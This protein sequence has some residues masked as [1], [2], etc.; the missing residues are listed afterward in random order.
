[1]AH[2]RQ[3]RPDSGLGSQAKVL[4]KFSVVPFL[5]GSGWGG[6]GCASSSLSLS[7]LEMS[8]AKVYEPSIRA[9]LGTAS[10]FCEVVVL[11]ERGVH[12]NLGLVVVH[13]HHHAGPAWCVGSQVTGVPRPQE[14]AHPFRT[15]LGP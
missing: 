11:N 8:D 7:S 9:L 4:E 5:R 10:H 14:N 13:G 1:M 3:S 2:T 15:H 12:L 6:E